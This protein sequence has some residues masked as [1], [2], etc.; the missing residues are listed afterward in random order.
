MSGLSVVNNPAGGVNLDIIGI[1]YDYAQSNT[2]N[3]DGTY[4]VTAT[5]K[6]GWHINV[7]SADAIDWPS[8]YLVT[9]KVQVRVWQ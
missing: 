4:D 5:A 8:E 1:V 7:R 3:A 2:Q 6:P 9:P